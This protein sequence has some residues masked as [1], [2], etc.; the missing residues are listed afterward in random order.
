MQYN[1]SNILLI[2]RV[3]YFFFTIS[4]KIAVVN[5]KSYSGHFFRI[6]CST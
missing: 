3:K 6:Q 2:L 5:D 4:Q 1:F